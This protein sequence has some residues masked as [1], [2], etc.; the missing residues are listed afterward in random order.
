MLASAAIQKK[1]S[2]KVSLEATQ[3]L[4]AVLAKL[5]NAPFSAEELQTVRAILVLQEIGT[6]EAKELLEPLA[7]GA[8]GALITRQARQAVQ[9]I[10]GKGKK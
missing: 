2:E 1:L 6:P 5:D 8:E 9:V 7:K 10:A 3:R 4:E